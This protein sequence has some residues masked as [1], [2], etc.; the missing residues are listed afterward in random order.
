M[1][2]SRHGCMEMHVCMQTYWC[3]DC[4][5]TTF[6]SSFRQY[7]KI[8]VRKVE[9]NYGNKCSGNEYITKKSQL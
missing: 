4:M 8:T 5:F 2:R 9:V 6:M 1:A 7:E 3:I